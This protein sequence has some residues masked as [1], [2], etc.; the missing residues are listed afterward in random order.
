MLGCE[1]PII[2][3]SH[4]RDVVAAV[5][6]AGGYGVLGAAAFTTDE[7]EVELKWLDEHTA[8]RSYGLDVLIPA[9]HGMSPGSAKHPLEQI[10]AA[11]REFLDD[12]LARYDVPPLADGQDTGDYA[13][14]TDPS[15]RAR[16][17]WDVAFQ[18]PVS[19]FVTA[20]GAPPADLVES[21][22]RDG[23]KV[24]G[25]V[26]KRAHA[27]HQ[28]DAGVDFV[29]AQGYE[30]GGHTGEI[31]TMVL[32]PEI[33][34]EVAPLPVAAAGGIASGR[35]MAAALALGAEAVWTGSVWLT[36][37]E[38]ETHPVVKEKFLNATSSDTLRSR[39]STGKPARQLR[40]AW[41][42]EW[43]SPHNPEPLQM[44]FHGVLVREA[45]A[46]IAGAAHRPGSG[47]E[48]LINYFVGQ[49][50]G[51]LTTVKTS[52]QV[53]LEMM[54]ELADVMGRFAAFAEEE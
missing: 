22:H 2:A 24:A 25:L 16:E 34:D 13:G 29:V 11:H 8:G 45:K 20:L 6:A 30:A 23:A 42:D 18:H 10:P 5:T 31:T 51:R 37:E 27:R 15:D 9:S 52:R 54:E 49:V 17:Q 48:K 41:T 44:P 46:R 53:L 40:S 3:F 21:A 19:L 43:E 47:A 26:G 38:A 12:L 36:T 7:L 1:Y 4:C 35:Q 50:V 14:A 39:S 33:V 32:V 28:R